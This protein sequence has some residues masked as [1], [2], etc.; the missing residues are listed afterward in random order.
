MFVANFSGLGVKAGQGR[1]GACGRG[2][3]GEHGA[4]LV[5]D[6]VGGELVQLL[7]LGGW[8]VQA[9][10]QRDLGCD[11]LRLL[12]ELVLLVLLVLVLLVLLVLVLLVVVVGV[13]DDRLELARVV[14]H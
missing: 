6:V 5:L 11:E 4:D 1:L 13:A 12:V 3:L 8:V 2:R 9:V 7:V 10:G 14:V